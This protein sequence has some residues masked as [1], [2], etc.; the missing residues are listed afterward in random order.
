MRIMPI[1]LFVMP[2]EYG[3]PS[4]AYEATRAAIL[5]SGLEI[6]SEQRIGDKASGRQVLMVSGFVV[7][8]SRKRFAGL[9][10]ACETV[11]I[12]L[13]Q[14]APQ[15]MAVL[16]DPAVMRADLDVLLDC[17]RPPDWRP[18]NQPA[19][20]PQL[21]ELAGRCNVRLS[22]LGANY[23]VIAS[24]GGPAGATWWL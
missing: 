15:I 5:A 11:A 2:D 24:T 19:L 14:L 10:P 18:D 23:E 3:P 20:P 21:V 13:T 12:R 9:R 8:V 1:E 6:V 7:A 17:G 16:A 4:P 22:V